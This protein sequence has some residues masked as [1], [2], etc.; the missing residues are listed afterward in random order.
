MGYP[1]TLGIR[2]AVAVVFGQHFAKSKRV[3]TSNWAA[4]NLSAQQLQYALAELFAQRRGIGQ[5]LVA[6]DPRTLR[7]HGCTA[8][9]PVCRIQRAAEFGNLVCVK[10]PGNVQQHVSP[11]C[12]NLKLAV[13]R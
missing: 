2:S 13:S 9:N 6:L 8:I 10:H 4:A 11:K 12:Q 5:L 3:T 7:A 1:R